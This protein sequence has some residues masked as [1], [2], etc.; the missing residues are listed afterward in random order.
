MWC[1]TSN[2]RHFITS[3]QYSVESRLKESLAV[4]PA[5]DLPDEDGGEALGPQPLVHAQEVYLHHIHG[6]GMF[7]T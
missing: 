5:R 1:D 3:L 4:D 6:P 2:H 7:S